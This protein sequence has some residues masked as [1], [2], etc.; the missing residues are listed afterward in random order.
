MEWITFF[1]I[2]KGNP[3]PIRHFSKSPIKKN[4]CILLPSSVILLQILQRRNRRKIQC[5]NNFHRVQPWENNFPSKPHKTKKNQ[6]IS[7]RRFERKP[8]PDQPASSCRSVSTGTRT[9][10]T[11][12]ART[13]FNRTPS[14]RRSF[15]RCV[16]TTIGETDVPTSSD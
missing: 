3:P 4:Q 6:T 14:R 11:F 2:S 15:R 9:S 8:Q 7:W 12:R 5:I 16:T 1:I 13:Q 10:I